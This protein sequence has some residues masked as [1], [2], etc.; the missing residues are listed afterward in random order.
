MCSG[1]NI[2]G[3]K[4]RSG[5]TEQGNTWLKDVLTECAWAGSHTRGTYLASQ[6]WRLT[7]RTGKR[8]AAIAVRSILTSV[9]V[10]QENHFDGQIAKQYD[11]DVS[12]MFDASVI[13]QTLDVLVELAGEGPALEFAIGTGRIAIPLV[14]AGIRVKGIELSAAMVDQLREK[15]GGREIS[16][17]IGDMTSTRVDDVFQL[18]YLVFNTIGNVPTQEGQLECF[19]NA[20]AHLAT[21][22]YFL[23]EVEIP[24]LRRLPPGCNTQ[25]FE[26]STTR[27]SFDELDVANQLG[28]SYHYS[29]QNGESS[30]FSVPFR[31]VWPSEL[32]LMA[33]FAG[34]KLHARWSDWDRSPFTDESEKHVSV[35]RKP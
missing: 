2:T 24:A 15:P 29:F 17:V 1:N 9:C 12:E 16:V 7:R 21:G 10:V 6:F 4:R 19:V 20:A 28:V 31:H 23:I 27:L 25:V 3:G 18:V 30:V 26:R 11:G 34:L 8:R 32:D 14:N 13:E 33:R 5:R 22:G 35:W